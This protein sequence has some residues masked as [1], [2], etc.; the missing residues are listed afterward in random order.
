VKDPLE[1]ALERMKPAPMPADLM[2][3]L[4]AARPQPAPERASFWR[5]WFV[6][7]AAGAT[8]A[9]ATLAWLNQNPTGTNSDIARRSHPVV[10]VESNDYLVGA[11]ELGVFVAPNQRPYRMVEVEWMEQ[12]TIQAEKNGP[13]MRVEK[14]RREVIP[15]AL[16]IY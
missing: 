7:L 4:T 15:V 14:K 1:E 2:A 10:P 6:P 16:D 8:A 3:R 11:R 9:V 12:D 13:A 5:R